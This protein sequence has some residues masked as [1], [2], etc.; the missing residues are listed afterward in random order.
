MDKMK[1]LMYSN[2]PGSLTTYAENL[3]KSLEKKSIDVGITKVLNYN[4]YR[5]YDIIHIQFEHTLFHPFGL[6]LII[7]LIILKMMGKK[8]VI[9]T[10]TVLAR[11]EIKS[12]NAFFTF[13]KNILFPLNEKLMSLVCDKLVVH[14]NSC[15]DILINEYNIP[16]DKI[17]VIEHAVD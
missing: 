13:L 7:H 8:I 3:K 11:K 2:D 9:T 5:D 10:H 16:K 15:K 14:T 17:E 4:T 12:I 6:R 1:I